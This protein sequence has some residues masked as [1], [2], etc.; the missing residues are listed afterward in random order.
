M[1]LL[2]LGLAVQRS[3]AASWA[4]ASRVAG[5]ALIWVWSR[6]GAAGLDNSP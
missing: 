2:A 3:D 1:I 4:G 5:L 6:I